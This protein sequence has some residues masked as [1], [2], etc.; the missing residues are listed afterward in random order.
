M[1]V[2]HS[3]NTARSNHVIQQLNL[4]LQSESSV[5]GFQLLPRILHLLGCLLFDYFLLQLKKGV[6]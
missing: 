5:Y 3:G 4:L 1:G 2:R 6:V